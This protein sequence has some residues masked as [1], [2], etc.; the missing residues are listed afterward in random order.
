MSLRSKS[1]KASASVTVEWSKLAPIAF[2]EANSEAE[3]VGGATIR[4]V[5]YTHLD[6]YKRQVPSRNLGAP[7]RTAYCVSLPHMG[8]SATMYGG[9]E[10]VGYALSLI[11]I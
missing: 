9:S 5:S 2:R 1:L 10:G 11:H 3:R 7:G 6:V 8:I 4:P